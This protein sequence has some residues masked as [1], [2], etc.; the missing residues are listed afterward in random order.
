M[1]YS[2]FGRNAIV[3]PDMG[4]RRLTS[5]ARSVKSDPCPFRYRGS[6]DAWY[7]TW[8]GNPVGVLIQGDKPPCGGHDDV[9]V[10]P[11]SRTGVTA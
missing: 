7:P 3:P 4:S 9:V 8:Q 6:P 2:C 1:L 11:S 10:W 5:P